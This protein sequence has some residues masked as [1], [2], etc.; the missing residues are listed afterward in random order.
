[1]RNRRGWTPALRV[2][3]VMKVNEINPDRCHAEIARM[4]DA[5][6]GEDAISRLDRCVADLQTHGAKAALT[7]APQLFCMPYALRSASVRNQAS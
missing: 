4:R 6:G 1:M 3:E 5:A 7:A 2:I